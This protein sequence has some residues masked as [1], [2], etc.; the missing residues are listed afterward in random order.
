MD[1]TMSCLV[2]REKDTMKELTSLRT[3]TSL[4]SW[5]SGFWFVAK[6]RISRL[7]GQTA[8]RL[9]SWFQAKHWMPGRILL[10]IAAA[11]FAFAFIFLLF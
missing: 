4:Q 2:F 10:A 3:S 1:K 8:T 11:A 9:R 6:M 7:N 5:M